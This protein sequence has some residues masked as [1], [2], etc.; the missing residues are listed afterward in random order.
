MI[1]VLSLISLCFIQGPVMGGGD[2]GCRSFKIVNV[3]FWNVS[4]VAVRIL[5]E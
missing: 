4:N 2:V 5:Q 3:A 1:L